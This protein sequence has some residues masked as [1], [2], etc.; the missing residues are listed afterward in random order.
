[1]LCGFPSSI[2]LLQEQQPTLLPPA[3]VRQESAMKLSG[4]EP[5]GIGR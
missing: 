4:R 3:P 5:W 1:M 2:H